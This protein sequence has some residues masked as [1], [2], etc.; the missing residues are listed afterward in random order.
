[1]HIQISLNKIYQVAINAIE[2]IEAYAKNGC[3]KSMMH[4]QEDNQY[5][6]SKKAE[7]YAKLITDQNLLGTEKSQKSIIY[8]QDDLQTLTKALPNSASWI[9]QHQ[10]NLFGFQGTALEDINAVQINSI[11]KRLLAIVKILTH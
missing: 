3:K 7:G 10:I 4:Y 1:M 9:S 8:F 2:K 11:Q 6:E 5:A